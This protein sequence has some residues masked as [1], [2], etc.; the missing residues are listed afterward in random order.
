MRRFLENTFLKARPLLNSAADLL[1]RR[2]SF[3]RAGSMSFA[4]S[5]L[6]TETKYYKNISDIERSGFKVYSQFDEDG[7]L[8]FIISKIHNPK[9][10]FIEFGVQDYLES[11]TRYL[12][13]KD[14]WEGLI[15]DGDKKAMEYIHRD[16]RLRDNLKA[17]NAF[18]TAENINELFES[19]GF[20]G[21]REIGIFSI[22]IDGND[23]WVWKAINCINPQIII[24]EYNPAF[25]YKRQIT[26]P[27][28]ADFVV[29][30]KTA[31]SRAYSGASLAAFEGLAKNWNKS[32]GGTL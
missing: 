29:N 2:S 12:H 8:Q 15:I 9:K 6:Y 31:T 23:Y 16:I 22:D 30:T 17:V 20:G 18:I 3:N 19:N 28:K 7:I 11:N 21:N 32:G 14:N 13:L 1:I 4:E 25:G 24:C 10:S 26:V 5:I 27:Y